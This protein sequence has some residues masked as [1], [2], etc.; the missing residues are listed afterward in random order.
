MAAAGGGLY[1]TPE[2]VVSDLG[3]D[4]SPASSWWDESRKS[5]KP[6]FLFLTDP[7]DCPPCAAVEKL[8]VKKDVQTVMSRF[9]CVKVDTREYRTKLRRAAGLPAEDRKPLSVFVGLDKKILTEATQTTPQG[10]DSFKAHLL[11]AWHLSQPP[12]KEPNENAYRTVG[13]DR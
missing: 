11:K 3:V 12:E 10:R 13:I 2:P 1:G 8:F 5:G 7:V 9:V 4:W 6:T